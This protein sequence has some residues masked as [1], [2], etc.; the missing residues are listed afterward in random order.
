MTL[1]ESIAK[2][3]ESLKKIV[4]AENTE[5][6]AQ[7]SKDLDEVE[8]L[9]KKIE[10]DNTSLK[11]RIVEMVKDSI[12]TK[13]P[14]DDVTSEKEKSLDDIMLEEAQKIQNQSKDK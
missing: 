7:V 11:D 12:S 3:K 10:T 9:G 5:A 6:V 8:N 4:T 14:K 2:V 13:T 1:E